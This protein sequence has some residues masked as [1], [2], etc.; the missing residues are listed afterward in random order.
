MIGK[1]GTRGVLFLLPL[2][3]LAGGCGAPGGGE[4]KS[5]AVSVDVPVEEVREP[6]TGQLER[7][8]TP[9]GWAL[10]RE[11]PRATADAILT[12]IDGI[13]PA[14]RYRTDDTLELTRNRSGAVVSFA[15]QRR[16]GERIITRRGENGEWAAG[17]ESETLRREVAR[18]EGEIGSS[19]WESMR[20]GGATPDLVVRFA[21]IFSW[22]FD[23]LTDCRKGD[24]FELVAEALYRGDVFHGYGEILA[25]RYEGTQGKVGGVRFALADGKTS[26]YAPDGSS[27]QKIFLRSPLNYR[28]ISS[29]FSKSRYHPI[30]KRRMPHLGIDYAAASGTPV[31]TVGDG[32][33]LFAGTKRGF[34]KIVEIRHARSYVTTYG[35]LSRF[36]RGLRKGAR[37]AQGQ[38]IG[39]VGSTGLSTAPHLDFRMK[40]GSNWVNP[41]R[42]SVPSADPVP[43]KERREFFHFARVCLAALDVLPEGIVPSE[44]DP[45]IP[46]LLA[47]RGSGFFPCHPD[48]SSPAP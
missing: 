4:E 34:G 25:A 11:I 46:A 12:S 14:S 7:G 32:T 33:V 40:H 48:V 29:G 27:L 41:L 1:S 18:F 3:L 47:G 30:L 17:R 44:R 42:I 13:L 37:V 36:G 38:V 22:T 35:H 2:L 23:F 8:E 15:V 5:A 28:R 16:N 45:I 43:R 6:V 31:V 9:M 21:D 24:R 20:A 26:Y 39:Y 19:L 10:R